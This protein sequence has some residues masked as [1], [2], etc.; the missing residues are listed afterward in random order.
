MIASL[1]YKV[2]RRLLE[3]VILRFRTERSKDLEIVVLRHE[4]GI[5]R[6]QVSRP[7]L[8]DTDRI[9]LAAASRVLARRR[10]ASFFVRPETLL[11]WHRR[12]VARRWTY[13]RRGPG[14]PPLDP[15]VESLIL[16]LARENR[17]WGYLR[18]QGELAGLGVRV[19][20]ITIR[21]VMA[22]AGPDPSGRRFGITWREFISTQARSILATDFLTVDTAL[23]RRLYVLFFIELDTRRVHLAGVTSHPTAAWIIQQA[24]NLFIAAD[25]GLSNRK[26]LIRDRDAKFTG[27]FDE[28]FRSEGLRVI[29]TPVRAPQANAYAERWV[30][31]LRRECLDWIL[32]IGRRHLESVLR[33]Y[34][35]HYNEHRPHRG[36]DLRAPDPPPLPL[37]SPP[38]MTLRS[39]HRRDRLG[40]LIHEYHLA[41]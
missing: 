34:V 4:L 35:A 19:S 16:Q 3:L 30:G 36:L 7:D 27:S 14:H 40:G 22:R 37:L 21:R 5:L 23:L 10:W 18:I 25:G 31:T 32:I 6:R 1:L 39:L 33:E 24:R 38:P 2:V 12:L 17:R 8:T 41:A 28:V 15:K 13:R 26:F 9:F 29:R 20:A 11:R